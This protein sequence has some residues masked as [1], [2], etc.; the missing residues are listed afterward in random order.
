MDFSERLKAKVGPLP[1]WAW[2]LLAGG[3]FTIWYWVS[4]RDVS[5]VTEGTEEEIAAEAGDRGSGPSG[6]FSTVPV[7]PTPEDKP[8]DESTNQ[9]WLRE[10]ISAG[11][12]AG[13]GSYLAIQSALNK[14]LNG[15]DVSAAEAALI[16]RVLAVVGPPPEGTQGTGAIGTDPVAPAKPVL[17]FTTVTSFSVPA[18]ARYGQTVAIR[19]NTKWKSAKGMSTPFPT[20]GRV[21]LKVGNKTYTQ[22]LVAGSSIRVI[23]VRKGDGRLNGSKV[24][25]SARFLPWKSSYKTRP[26]EAAPK[27][28]TFK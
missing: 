12:N 26:S 13:A 27:T 21:L 11:A 14:Y 28:I 20:A 16:N 15:Q 7:F 2:G 23:R 18:T 5:E 19:V 25:V 24:I 1:V 6:D 3:A 4:Q 8:D 9:E 17:D 10:A 22:R